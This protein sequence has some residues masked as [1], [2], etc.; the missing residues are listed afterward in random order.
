MT[1]P[2]AASRVFLHD[3]TVEAHIGYYDFE[4]GV[5]QPLVIDVEISIDNIGSLRQPVIRLA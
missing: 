2:A 5:T 3:L 1:L 4:K